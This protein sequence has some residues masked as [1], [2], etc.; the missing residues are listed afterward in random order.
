MRRAGTACKDIKDKVGA[1]NDPAVKRL[2][3]VAHLAGGELIIKD[4][5]GYVIRGNKLSDLFDLALIDKCTRIGMFNPLQKVFYRFCSRCLCQ[6]CQL[7]KIIA[8]CILTDL[9]SDYPD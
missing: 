2:L 1:V 9:R 8:G 7:V 6:E 3:Y 5:K 4:G